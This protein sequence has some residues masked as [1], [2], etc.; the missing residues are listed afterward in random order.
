MPLR[1]DIE[2]QFIEAM[3]AKNAEKLSALRNLRSAL[4]NYAIDK[5]ASELT[6]EMIVEVVAR[7]VKKLKDALADF[8]K[9]G[10]ED[11]ASANRREIETLAAWLPKQLSAEEVQAVV[12]QVAAE[13]GLSGPAAFGRLMGESMK[14]LK[15][16]ADGNAVGAAAKVI[17]Q[18]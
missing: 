4:K 18:S 5:G 3:K 6:D 17:L 7:E 15:G 2:K 13:L 16:Q 14:R 9:A 11:L 10:R 1:D 12:R 8:E